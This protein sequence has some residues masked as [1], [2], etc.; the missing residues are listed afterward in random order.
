MGFFC[1]IKYLFIKLQS[2]ENGMCALCILADKRNTY[3]ETDKFIV[4][5]CDSCY[6]P[7]VV[8]KEHTMSISEENKKVMENALREAAIK[9]Y[10]NE[11][12][13]HIDKQQNDILDHLHWHA[14]RSQHDFME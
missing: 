4:L 7:M 11:Y 9:H 1:A 6:V 10:G 5:D 2:K 8:W 13:W 12:A 14:R 3:I